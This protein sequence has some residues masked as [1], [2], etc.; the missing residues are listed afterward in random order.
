MRIAL[1]VAVA[2]GLLVVFEVIPGWVA[3]LVAAGVLA[4]YVFVGRD[5]RSD[6]ARQTSWI[7]ALSQAFVALVPVLLFVLGVLAVIALAVLA[8]VAVIALFADRR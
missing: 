2:E 7:A 6:L 1:W 8:L 3:L 4:F 5:L